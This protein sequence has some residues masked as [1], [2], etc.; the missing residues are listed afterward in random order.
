MKSKLF[1]LLSTFLIVF[2]SCQKKLANFQ[3]SK[4]ENYAQ[5]K[6]KVII[7]PNQESNDVSANQIQNEFLTPIITQ[8][9]EES[10]VLASNSNE[11]EKVEI[12]KSDVSK[13]VKNQTKTLE[14]QQITKKIGL[15]EKVKI[16][17]SITKIKKTNKA[18]GN[19]G[20]DQ[21]VAL[22]LVVLVGG[23]GIHRFYLGY[24]AIGVIQLL[25]LGG[26]GIWALI[27]LIRIITGDLKPYNGE[28]TR[29]I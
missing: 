10:L 19:P 13:I 20:T 25:T 23:L 4:H 26:C 3:P 11:I 18:N 6:N 16:A 27:D 5:T 28:Y 8:K 15:I 9:T 7:L 17:K 24:T 22:L 2:G 21:L 29:K 14:N 1:I 12:T